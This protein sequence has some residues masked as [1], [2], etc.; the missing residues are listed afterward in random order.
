MNK[1][2]CMW[3]T[4]PEELHSIWDEYICDEC[5]QKMADKMAPDARISNV[6]Y[7]GD[8]WRIRCPVCNHPG[9]GAET[10]AKARRLALVE[11]FVEKCGVLACRI[12]CHE[13]I[14]G[15]GCAGL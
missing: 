9:P 13:Q 6:V 5:L 4:S 2:V 12:I 10:P 1:E 3:C 14:T 7:V 11:E 8:C 15:L